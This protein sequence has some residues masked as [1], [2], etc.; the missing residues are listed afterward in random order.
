VFV[1]RDGKIVTPPLGT[2]VLPGITRD[3]VLTLAGDLGIPIVE[4]VIPRE[5][6]YIADEVFFSGT[7]AEIS[8][9][10]SVDRITIG[11]GRRGPITERLQNEFFG[12]V[13]GTKP[14][15]YGWLTPVGVAAPVA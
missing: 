2:S 1:V 13:N 9:I 8:P 15:R 3:A 5:L 12:I 4:Q 7:A 11:S 6:L 14:D 10:R